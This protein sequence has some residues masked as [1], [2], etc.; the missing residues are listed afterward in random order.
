VGVEYAKQIK[1][2]GLTIKE[3]LAKINKTI[4]QISK[5]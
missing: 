2:S 4:N 1:D 5:I 3:F